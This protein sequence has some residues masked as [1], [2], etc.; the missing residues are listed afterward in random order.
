ML[1][2]FS[3][4]RINRSTYNQLAI[5]G[6]INADA[7]YSVVEEN[8]SSS[9]YWG[10]KPAVQGTGQLKPVYTIVRPYYE[11]YTQDNFWT[12]LADDSVPV[13]F[14]VLVCGPF[15]TVANE[16]IWTVTGIDFFESISVTP[17]V[18]GVPSYFNLHD[19]EKVYIVEKGPDGNPIVEIVNEGCSVRIVT[20]RYLNWFISYMMQVI[21]TW[22]APL[23]TID[24]G[25]YT[26][27]SI[28]DI[29]DGRPK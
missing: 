1:K 24:C 10:T 13:G 22:N 12:N 26:E 16:D 9:L 23:D 29:D 14:R 7:L 4:N 5:D 18:Y 8:G 19:G 2:P 6:E 3:L 27:G 25:S 20:F 21:A 28:T 15:S 17:D 11:T